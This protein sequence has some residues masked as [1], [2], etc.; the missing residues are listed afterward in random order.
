MLR[1]LMLVLSLG[2][3]AAAYAAETVEVSYEGRVVEVSPDLAG[4]V[5]TCDPIRGRYR[6]RIRGHRGLAPFVRASVPNGAT[7]SLRLD[8]AADV[9]ED[10]DG[11]I[12]IIG[13]NAVNG[14][15]EGRQVQVMELIFE[16]RPFVAGFGAGMLNL[17]YVNAQNDYVT[18]SIRF[19]PEGPQGSICN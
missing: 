2:T 12:S 6:V 14:T 8:T 7:W 9:A 1:K 18:A 11:R 3:C 16:R 4:I 17:Y 19:E 5:S 13:A 15:V 10:P